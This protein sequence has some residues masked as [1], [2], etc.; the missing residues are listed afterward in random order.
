MNLDT[1]EDLLRRFSGF[2]SAMASS[3]K[4][5]LAD[6]DLPYMQ[7][8]VLIYVDAHPGCSQTEI[9]RAYHLSRAMVSGLLNLLS[10]RAYVRRS[11]DPHDSRYNNVTL[12]AEGE[13]L[14]KAGA[15]RV[16]DFCCRAF[17]GFSEEELFF[18][19]DM[20]ARLEMNIS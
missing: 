20:L 8:L 14:A 11:V 13:K 12:T 17:G 5:E 19:Q 9:A 7:L 10:E 18:L 15:V 16:Q 2:S 4:K 1:K 3:A 6:F